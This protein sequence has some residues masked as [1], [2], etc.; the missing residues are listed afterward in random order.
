MM[1]TGSSSRPNG[2]TVIVIGGGIVGVTTADALQTRGFQVTLIERNAEV[3][4]FASRANAGLVSVGCSQPWNAPSVPLTVLKTLGRADSPYLFRTAA[5]PAITPWAARFLLR[6]RA[7]TY[8][9]SCRASTEL[10]AYSLDRFRQLDQ[11][12]DLAFDRQRN[13]VLKYFENRE[14]LDKEVAQTERQAGGPD[15]RVLDAQGMV[16]LEPTLAPHQS[17]IAGGLYFPDDESGDAN[18]FARAL[19]KRFLSLGGVVRTGVTVERLHRRDDRLTGIETDAGEF[20]ADHYV[21]CAGALAARF[22]RQAGIRLPVYPVKGYSV[23]IETNGDVPLPRVPFLDWGRKICVTRFGNRIRA[24]GTAEFCGIDTTLTAS[25]LDP[26][27]R[28][29]LKLFPDLG[30]SD[31]VTPWAGLRPVT[32]DG[33]P[34]LGASPV[35]NLFLNVGHGPQGWGLSCGTAAIVADVVS[36]RPTDLALGPYAYARG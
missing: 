2:Q 36:G 7:A 24:A 32:P 34:I 28:Y 27:H 25:R 22:G 10:M 29:L 13:G 12:A 11:E 3:A 8:D 31:R 6:C 14:A 23:T 21:L 9:A 5:F 30:S 16:N 20:V 26:L 18:A 35:G 1:N 33:L 19:A 4:E 15:Y 17:R